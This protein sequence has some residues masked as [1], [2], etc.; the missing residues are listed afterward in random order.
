[1][2]TWLRKEPTVDDRNV[3]NLTNKERHI[4]MFSWVKYTYFSIFPNP[5]MLFDWFHSNTSIHQSGHAY[6][7]VTRQ[8]I[9][10]FH[11]IEALFVFIDQWCILDVWFYARTEFFRTTEKLAGLAG[12]MQVT[13]SRNW[14]I[15]RHIYMIFHILSIYEIIRPTI[16]I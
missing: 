13:I 10:Y 8:R 2:S 16:R 9:I 11:L 15:L 14:I 5:T 3:S 6:A 1:M 12:N 4:R 7:R